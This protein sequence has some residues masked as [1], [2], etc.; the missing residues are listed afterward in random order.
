MDLLTHYLTLLTAI[1][2]FAL[3]LL[4][5]TRDKN[6]PLYRAFFVF[7]IIDALWVFLNYYFWYVPSIFIFRSQYAFG[8]A[9]L[10][11]AIIWVLY[12]TENNIPK[13][14]LYLLSILTILIFLLPYIDG[15]LIEGLLY[16]QKGQ[17]DFKS[18]IGFYPYGIVLLTF[19]FYLIYKPYSVYRKS[20]GLMRMQLRYALIGMV[21][22]VFVSTLFGLILPLFGIRPVVAY[23]AQ[24]SLFWVAFTTYA[25]IAHQLFDIRIIIKKTVEYSGL[26]IFALVTYSMIVFFFSAALGNAQAITWENQWVNFIAAALIAFGFDPIRKYL[27]RVT[28]KYLFKGEYDPQAVLS[29]LSSDLSSS[30][31]MRQAA[32]SLVTIIKSE[33]RLTHAAVIVFLSEEKRIVI[34]DIVQDGYLNPDILTLRPENLLLQQCAR[35]PQVIIKD[36]FR[37]VCDAT[38]K[39]S[40]E[41]RI[42]H[43]LLTD[44]DK[45]QASIIVPI[46]VAE[47]AIGMFIIGDKLSGDAFTKDEVEF[48]TIVGSQTA[49]AIEKAR[50]WEEDQMKT[51]F[52][53]IASHELLTPTAAMK[54]YLSMILDDNMGKVD[55]TA[56]RYLTKVAESTDRL[57]KLV[58]DLLNV[59]RI[60]SGRIKINRREFSL[61]DSVKK[62]VDELQ[63]KAKEKSLELSYIAPKEAVPN[64]YADPEHI[65]RILVNLIGN[66][67]KYTQQ[68]WVRCY[69][70]QQD[71]Q[72]LLFCVSDSGVGIPQ[73]MI[74]HLFEKFYR[75]ERQEIAGTQG[76]GLGLY[77]SQKIIELL[78]GKI[79]VKS[80]HG[81]GSSFFVTIPIAN[82]GTVEKKEI[83]AQAEVRG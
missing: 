77:I 40:Q 83:V 17:Y 39:Q 37:Q 66:A 26:L 32:Q 53:S 67:I 25:I 54:G 15:L 11:S 2:N 42:C 52:V 72:F 62:A 43:V 12:L 56:R 63:V 49:N 51:E 34:K 29:K 71:P 44:I 3:G 14:K 33:M 13:T 75:A 30:L 38:D 31:D 5:I 74:P 60:E 55:D 28:D 73:E 46:L 69:V 7:T 6:R 19:L 79:W 80:E 18:G 9:V 47:K 57:A 59:S 78:G 81:Q 82:A 70:T 68:G 35:E 21:I 65:Y 8:G 45:L 4:V 50:F 64:V 23:D 58:E 27:I 36:D 20:S 16:I 41:S 48:L 10:G 22:F 24:S 1:A 61:V 76:S